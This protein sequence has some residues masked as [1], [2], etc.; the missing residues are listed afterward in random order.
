MLR[1]LTFRKWLYRFRR[2]SFEHE[3]KLAN[4]VNIDGDL[5][6]LDDN[7]HVRLC[8]IDKTAVS[9]AYNN[10]TRLQGSRVLTLLIL[11]SYDYTVHVEGSRDNDRK[12]TY[13]SSFKTKTDWQ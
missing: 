5:V 6:L 4:I 3:R 8:G 9:T 11:H 12:L 2:V 7:C 13:S 10:T 1:T